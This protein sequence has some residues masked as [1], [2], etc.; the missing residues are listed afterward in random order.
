MQCFSNEEQLR[1]I[2][3]YLM[4]LFA[5]VQYSFTFWLF[6]VEVYALQKYNKKGFF[7]S[8]YATKITF[9]KIKHAS[10]GKMPYKIHDT[11]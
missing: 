8:Q 2:T 9:Y 5:R 6:I 10:A 11:F 4:Q 3:Y 7:L 1:K